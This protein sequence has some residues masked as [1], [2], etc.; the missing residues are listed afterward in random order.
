MESSSSTTTYK[1]KK[2]SY[3]RESFT[4]YKQFY[5]LFQAL[6]I[7]KLKS[8]NIKGIMQN[9][10]RSKILE[11]THHTDTRI[12]D[13]I[14]SIKEKN[15]DFIGTNNV[16]YAIDKSD[17]LSEKNRQKV[18]KIQAKY[19]TEIRFSKTK[20]KPVPTK[21]YFEKISSTLLDIFGN[22]IHKVLMT[23]LDEKKLIL[24]G[25]FLSGII[26]DTPSKD[27]DLFLTTATTV[28]DIK[29]LVELFRTEKNIIYTDGICL[30]VWNKDYKV[31]LVLV[32]YKYAHDLIET[33][34]LS[35]SMFAYTKN[36]LYYNSYSMYTIC[37]GAILVNNQR[38]WSRSPVRLLKYMKR[39]F[40]IHLP[41]DPQDL[42]NLKDVKMFFINWINPEYI[43][44]DDYVY[45]SVYKYLANDSV[46]TVTIEEKDTETFAN[47][48]DLPIYHYGK[49]LGEFVPNKKELSEP[50]LVIRE[51]DLTTFS[52]NLDVYFGKVVPN[53]FV[54]KMADSFYRP[55]IGRGVNSDMDEELQHYLSTF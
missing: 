54:E 19:P 43:E 52:N 25:G 55:L 39:G 42:V 4:T 53:K 27:I 20:E 21:D 18:A 6:D 35:C 32:R 28:D 31:D 51:P 7:N 40:G 12:I 26:F 24:A 38:Y 37:T 23:L 34:D 44:E 49:K 45:Y 29:E 13:E 9:L 50:L 46:R 14:M 41:F 3:V 16:R 10:K 36:R 8:D 22:D 30:K 47:S 48:Y 11:S 15:R 17:I 33:F 1:K 2:A 5:E